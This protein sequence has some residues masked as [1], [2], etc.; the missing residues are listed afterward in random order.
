[1]WQGYCEFQR[2]KTD[3]TANIYL[4]SYDAIALENCI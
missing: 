3:K 1:M 2:G 4:N